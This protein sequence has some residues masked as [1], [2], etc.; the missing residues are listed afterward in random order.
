MKDMHT[1]I[2][3]F[4]RSLRIVSTKPWFSLAVIGML[5]LG[6]AGN[7]AVFSVFNSLFL[8]QLRYE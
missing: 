2:H 6:I 8:R 5:A 3:P 4:T 1:L 7:S